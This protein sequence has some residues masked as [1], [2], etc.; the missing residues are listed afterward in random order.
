[1]QEKVT[2]VKSDV[3]GPTEEFLVPL[4]CGGKRTPWTSK[5]G[6]KSFWFYSPRYLHQDPI[7]I[8]EELPVKKWMR[9]IFIWMTVKFWLFCSSSANFDKL[10]CKTYFNCIC[11]KWMKLKGKLS[12]EIMYKDLMKTYVILCYA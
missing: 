2:S 5:E 11:D 10:F 3:C 6:Y 4:V 7:T 8:N 12:M 1:M 9:Y